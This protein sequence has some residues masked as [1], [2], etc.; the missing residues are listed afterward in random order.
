LIPQTGRRARHLGGPNLCKSCV[1]CPLHIPSSSP[2]PD[3]D[4]HCT[5][6]YLGYPLGRFA[7]LKHRQLGLPATCFTGEL[8]SL[9]VEARGGASPP[10][11]GS[12][13]WP[14]MI[15]HPSGAVLAVSAR[16]L[17]PATSIRGARSR[18]LRQVYPPGGTSRGGEA[19]GGYRRRCGAT[20]ARERTSQANA[21]MEMEHD[22]LDHV[23]E[24][25]QVRDT[26]TH[27]TD[28]VDPM[29]DEAGSRPNGGRG[30][31]TVSQRSVEPPANHR[32]SSL[33]KRSTMQPT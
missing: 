22:G 25:N 23:L 24:L 15:H 11:T 2:S 20:E 1:P 17:L 12:A 31:P 28:W 32:V 6:Y 29:V 19:G 4:P 33:F 3:H 18:H 10:M 14:E 16:K 9:T 27:P 5:I 8:V 13:A 30:T 21:R 26:Q 7:G